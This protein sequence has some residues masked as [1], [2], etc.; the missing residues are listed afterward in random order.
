MDDFRLKCERVSKSY[1]KKVFILNDISFELTNGKIIGIVGRNGSG[2]STLL[3]IL[4]GIIKPSLGKVAL[5]IKGINIKPDIFN[6]YFGFVAPYLNLYEEF[7]AYEHAKIFC[8][9]KG[10]NF[11]QN[12]V[13][14]YLDMF[15]I[16]K[17]GEKYISKFS[18]GM[19]KR[20]KYVLAFIHQPHILLLDEPYANLDEPGIELVEK[21]I[22]NH[23][24]KSGG[25]IIASN[26]SREKSLCDEIINLDEI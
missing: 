15:H 5:S 24:K 10:I 1:I 16:N 13:S 12:Q 18:S 11:N 23:Q 8:G 20:M 22:L 19:K 2:K 4:A 21:A 26:D 7:T 17:T 6:N 14:E 3:K 25:I 9:L